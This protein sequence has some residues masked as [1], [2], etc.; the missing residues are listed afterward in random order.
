LRR[1]DDIGYLRWVTISKRLGVRGFHMEAKAL[2]E[3]P[4]PRLKLDPTGV[5]RMYNQNPA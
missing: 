1:Y 2:L 3:H 4:S 5:P